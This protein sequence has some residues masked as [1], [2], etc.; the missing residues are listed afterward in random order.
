MKKSF[1]RNEDWIGTQD[2]SLSLCMPLVE[3]DMKYWDILVKLLY[4][5]QST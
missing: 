5:T 2:Q 3:I 1:T 4:C